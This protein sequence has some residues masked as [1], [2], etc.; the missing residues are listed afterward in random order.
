M[1]RSLRTYGF[2]VRVSYPFVLLL[3]D[4]IELFVGLAKKWLATAP[5]P[6]HLFVSSLLIPLN[7][8]GMNYVLEYCDLIAL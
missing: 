3:Y 1:R 2:E 7:C 5:N 8:R 6:P 4:H